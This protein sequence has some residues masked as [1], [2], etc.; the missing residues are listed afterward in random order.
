MLQTGTLPSPKERPEEWSKWAIKT[1]HGRRGS[2]GQMPLIESPL[3][4]G[5]AIMKWWH[6]IQPMFRQTKNTHPSTIVVPPI[7][8]SADVWAPLRK[9]GPNGLVIILVLLSWWGHTAQQLIGWEDNSK[10]A[11]EKTVADVRQVLEAIA[12]RIP[13]GKRAGDPL[14]Q[15]RKRQYVL[16]S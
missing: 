15:K 2:Y 4:F 12:S 16:L 1:S 7:E 8:T 13:P 5:M 14:L 10:P 3:E 9:C 11:W 6:G